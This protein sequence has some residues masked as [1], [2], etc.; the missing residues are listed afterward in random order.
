MEGS[1]DDERLMDAL[2]KI[3]VLE[4][5]VLGLK[6]NIILQ[7]KEYQRRLAE[8]N[9]AH[10]QA[11]SDK[12]AFLRKETFDAKIAEF[13]KWQN[14]MDVWRSRVIGIGVGAGIGGGLA[15]GG[16]VALLMKLFQ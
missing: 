13:S 10:E 14:E 2:I 8:L 5:E 7:A 11:T 16:A 6:E 15:S 12:A 3:A 1:Q 9:H 4:T